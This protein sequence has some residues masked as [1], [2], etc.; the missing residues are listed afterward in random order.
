MYFYSV[1]PGHAKIS[2]RK[3]F[4]TKNFLTIKASYGGNRIFTCSRL[5]QVLWPFKT[6]KLFACALLINSTWTY[7]RAGNFRMVQIF[8]YFERIQ[9]V[10]K[11]ENTKLFSREYEITRFFTARQLFVYYRTQDV[12]VRP[13]QYNS[14]FLITAAG[15][16]ACGRAV[17][18]IIHYLYIILTTWRP[19][20]EHL[21]E[22]YR[23][24]FCRC[25]YTGILF[26]STVM[27]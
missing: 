22:K 7:R 24:E 13:L 8:A 4:F 6:A 3:S 9:I 16:P 21:V 26:T 17:N 20:V 10:E 27:R 23:S 25:E 19:N 11:L 2:F 1:R 15:A 14:L 5:R 12:P 18:I